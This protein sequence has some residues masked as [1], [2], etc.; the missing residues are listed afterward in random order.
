M[1][2]VHHDPAASAAR[3]SRPGEGQPRC[4]VAELLPLRLHYKVPWPL[5]MIVDDAVLVK[6]NSVL[7]FLLQVSLSN[8]L[9]SHLRMTSVTNSVGFVA[10]VMKVCTS[11][12]PSSAMLS[13]VVQLC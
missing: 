9:V 8:P 5:S 10:L 1:E 12:R 6:Y 7:T 4:H 11:H 13:A 2:L 3:G